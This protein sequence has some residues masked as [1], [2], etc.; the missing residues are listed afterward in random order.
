MLILY[1]CPLLEPAPAKRPA[2]VAS[3]H[4]LTVFSHVAYTERLA[5]CAPP[6]H[7]TDTALLELRAEL[8]HRLAQ[9]GCRLHALLQVHLHRDLTGALV[10]LD[11]GP[12]RRGAVD[13]AAARHPHQIHLF[14]DE[15][16]GPLSLPPVP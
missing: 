6:Q 16:A 7:D 9:P 13:L 10:Y 3:L 11:L 4:H 1:P 12:S 2:E 5:V 15:P 8:T 14:L